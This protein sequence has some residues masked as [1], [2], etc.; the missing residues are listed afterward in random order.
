MIAM[1]VFKGASFAFPPVFAVTFKVRNSI[2]AG[3][4]VATWIRCAIVT[5]YTAQRSFPSFVADTLEGVYFVYA[6]SAVLAR[7]HFTIVDV[8]MTVFASVAWLALA[9]VA[10]SRLVHAM[11]VLPTLTWR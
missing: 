6:G 4:V 10:N 2:D 9:F 8:F 3:A 5:I 7:V 1:T 11:S